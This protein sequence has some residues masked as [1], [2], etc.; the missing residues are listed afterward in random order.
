VQWGCAALRHAPAPGI[1]PSTIELGAVQLERVPVA[2]FGPVSKMQIGG[3]VPPGHALV[4]LGCTG[5][6]SDGG[7]RCQDRADAWKD[8][9]GRRMPTARDKLKIPPGPVIAAAFSAGGQ[10]VKRLALEP[11][12]RAELAGVYLADATYT[13]KWKDK[14]LAAIDDGITH[15]FVLFALDAIEDGRPLVATASSSPNRGS[16]SGAQTL[17]AIWRAI[18]EQSGRRFVDAASDPMLEGLRPPRRAGR[19]GSVL[20]VDFGDVY[21]HG[22]HATVIAPVML[23]RM[24]A[25]GRMLHQFPPSLTTSRDVSPGAPST[26]RRWRW[27]LAAAAAAAT[28]WA[29]RRRA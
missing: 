14:D 23:P 20:L 1:D 4:V 12:D 16:P 3:S 15:G 5:D 10:I 29:L 18:E 25:Q 17:D 22:E 19:I 7:P 27:W 11:A 21:Q 2:W 6:G 28:W 24:L 8:A 9:S 13:V 26:S